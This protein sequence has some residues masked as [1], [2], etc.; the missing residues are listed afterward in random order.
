MTQVAHRSSGE[1]EPLLS[2]LGHAPASLAGVFQGSTVFLVC[3]G[4]SLDAMNVVSPLSQ[5]GIVTCAVNNAATVLRPQIW[6]SLDPPRRFSDAIWIDPSII[7]FVPNAHLRQTIRQRDG[8]GILQETQLVAGA[9][10]NVWGFPVNVSFAPDNWLREKSFNCGGESVDQDCPLSP[11]AMR[12]VFIVALRLLFYLGFRRVFLLGVDFRMQSK[13][14]NYAF[15]QNRSHSSVRS[16]NLSY[17]IMNERMEQLRPEF[18]RA[19][20]EVLNCNPASGLR[21]FP[22][23]SFQ[24]AVDRALQGF[25]K[26]LETFG[27][28]DT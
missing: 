1:H 17:R 22:Y 8:N 13:A 3:S 27:L 28:Y 4:P 21:V 10:A 9:Q 5:R 7:K 14:D 25:P 11:Y 24:D 6:V 2:R 12:S 26:K 20:Y 16:N 19:G 18:E 15:D 23:L